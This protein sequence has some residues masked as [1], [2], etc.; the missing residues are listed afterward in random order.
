MET[1][2]HRINITVVTANETNPFVLDYFAIYFTV[3]ESSSIVETSS[4]VPSPTSTSSSPP[5]TTTSDSAT[6]ATTRATPVG[7]IA[8]GVIGGI[9]ILVFALWYFLRKR[10]GGGRPYY[11]ER[12]SPTEILASEGLYTFLRLCYRER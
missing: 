4:S 11:F 7:A 2:V 1:G 12:P 10:H 6:V 5:I 9:A 3:G 8:G